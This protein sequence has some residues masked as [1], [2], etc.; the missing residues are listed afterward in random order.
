[1]KEIKEDLNKWNE[2]NIVKMSLLPKLIYRFKTVL[3]KLP[4]GV[5]VEIDTLTKI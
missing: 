5:L 1:M 2:D 3:I 4:S